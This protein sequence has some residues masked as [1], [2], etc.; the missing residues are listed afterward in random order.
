[1]YA[2]FA[3]VSRDTTAIFR[4]DSADDCSLVIVVCLLDCSETRY[5]EEYSTK[6][7]GYVTSEG[8]GDHSYF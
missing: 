7:S 3:H 1:M 2:P 6:E 4:R 5:G 8:L